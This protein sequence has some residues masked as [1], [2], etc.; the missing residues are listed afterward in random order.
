MVYWLEN[1]QFGGGYTFFIIYS[2]QKLYVFLKKNF[3][4]PFRNFP[5]LYFV[6]T[7]GSKSLPFGICWLGRTRCFPYVLLSSFGLMMT[8]SCQVCVFFPVFLLC[9]THFCRILAKNTCSFFFQAVC[10]KNMF[11]LL[12]PFI[13]TNTNT[14]KTN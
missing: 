9:H 13:N 8:K 1:L 3:S 12:S 4:F 6:W 11:G 10:K 2:W 14:K 7:P 5:T